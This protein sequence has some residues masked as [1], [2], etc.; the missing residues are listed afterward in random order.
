M[1]FR[2]TEEDRDPL[3]LHG[4]LMAATAERR[5]S[6]DS[7]GKLWSLC[8]IPFFGSNSAATSSP[9][10]ST[11]T[12]SLTRNRD[13]LG[14]GRSQ[15]S[16][17]ANG[18]TRKSS[19]SDAKSVSSVAKWLLPTRRRLRLDPSTKLYFPCEFLKIFKIWSF[20]C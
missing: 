9:A 19:G 8:R 17:G 15:M 6:A 4:L 13:Q 14:S 10:N 18:S 3:L 11:A 12:Q 5:A 16:Q 20:S 2:P 7:E 1:L